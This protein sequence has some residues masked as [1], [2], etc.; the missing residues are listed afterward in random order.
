MDSNDCILEKPEPNI[1]LF[2]VDISKLFEIPDF[3]LTT[4]ACRAG[5]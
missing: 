5:K 2:D 3:K 4:K 1:I